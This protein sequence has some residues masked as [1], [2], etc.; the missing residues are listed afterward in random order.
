[1]T[2]TTLPLGRYSDDATPIAAFRPW[3]LADWTDALFVHFA[4]DPAILRPHVP[5]DLDLFNGHAYV[6][7]VAFTQS[8][9]RPA[10]GGQLTA[11]TM[12]PIAHHAFLNLRTYVRTPA[13]AGIMF[14]AEWIPNR[15]ALLVGPHLYGLPFRLGHL[16]YRPDVRHVSTGGEA[17]RL[18]VRSTF[19]DARPDALDHFLL[20]RY[21]AVTARK[22]RGRMFHI[23]H[24]PWEFE[25][26]NVD[27]AD[28]AL[29]RRAAPWFADAK[30]V[31]AHLSPGV[32]DVAIGGPARVTL[33][34][35]DARTS[36]PR[37]TRPARPSP[38]PAR[39]T[40][41]VPSR[42]NLPA[43]PPP[44]VRSLATGP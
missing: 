17:L 27:V 36:S 44:C 24:D 9:L 6:S 5:F 3:F 1:M 42:E 31:R 16:D 20:E 22:G 41:S 7:L 37:Q 30:L 13:H 11:W 35:D 19:K 23:R 8:R 39:R 18:D 2:T 15:L 33:A 26:V 29:I 12:A 34:A 40:P 10:L 14:L 38:V 25:R 21:T 4:I 32:F 43:R 28:D